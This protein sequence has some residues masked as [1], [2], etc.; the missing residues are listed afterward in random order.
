ML[1]SSSPAH[2]SAA[3]TA[4]LA[5][6]DGRDTALTIRQGVQMGRPS[7]IRTSAS[8]VDGRVTETRVAGSAVTVAEGRLT[9]AHLDF[10]F[11]DSEFISFLLYFEVT[12]SL[13]PNRAYYG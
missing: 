13:E 7:L 4:Y 12:R 2:S 8:F 5:T 10:L 1:A 3:L 9:L 11:I 6:L